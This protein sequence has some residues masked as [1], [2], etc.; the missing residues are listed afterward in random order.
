VENCLFNGN[1]VANTI[2]AYMR[3]L[4]FKFNE[5]EFLGFAGS[6]AVDLSFGGDSTE[7][8]SYNY[9]RNCLFSSNTTVAVP[10]TKA[11][12]GFEDYDRTLNNTQTIDEFA[13]S[14]SVPTTQSDST[15]VRSGGSIQSM[16]VT[17]NNKLSTSSEMS[18]LMLFEIPIYTTTASK[19]YTVYFRPS[20][21]GDWSA[22]PTASELWIELEAWGHATNNFRQITKSTGTIDMNGSTDWQALTVTVAPAQAGVAYLK[23][24][25]AKTKEAGSNIFYVD[26][27]PIIS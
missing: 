11:F 2:G 15:I 24:W 1:S 7:T 22:D 8:G 26:P 23:C 17:P 16:K 27:V 3:G 12:V 14:T 6:N 9:F 21:T 4:Y 25:Y 5:C 19:I 10:V 20:A 13:S 18:R